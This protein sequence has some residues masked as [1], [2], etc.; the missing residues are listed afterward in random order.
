M[1]PFLPQKLTVSGPSVLI[2]NVYS[3]SSDAYSR[4]R[5][6]VHARRCGSV[7]RENYGED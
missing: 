6:R 7:G 5:V 1:E 2:V 3:R 4:N